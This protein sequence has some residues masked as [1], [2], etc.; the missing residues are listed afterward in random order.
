MTD[1]EG[2]Y[3]VAADERDVAL[4]EA[5]RLRSELREVRNDLL[6]VRGTLSPN[7]YEP[8]TPLSLVP[9]VAPAVDWLVRQAER[10]RLAWTSARRRAIALRLSNQVRAGQLMGSR[11]AGEQYQVERDEARAEVVR[12][13]RKSEELIEEKRRLADALEVAKAELGRAAEQ[14]RFADENRADLAREQAE[15]FG[16][17]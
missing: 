13:G 16:G 2:M 15:R 11:L 12:L 5:G 7:G 6:N 9:N 3:R 10:Y 17:R 8:K 4:G 14:L 1:F